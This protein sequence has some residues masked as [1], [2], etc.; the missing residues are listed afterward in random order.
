VVNPHVLNS[1]GQPVGYKL[2]T[3]E[4]IL[5]F[6]QDDASILDRAKFMTKHLWVTPYDQNERYPTGEYPN[7]HP[8]GEG[9]PQWTQA[10]RSIEDTNIVVWYNFGHH[11][12]PRPEDWS[13]MPTAY[14]GFK[15]LPVGFFDRNPAIDLPAP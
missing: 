12:I 13:V 4:N 5:P 9:L 1:W 7:Q 8:G 14:I 11:H 2:V 6:A 3:G 15:L 10:N